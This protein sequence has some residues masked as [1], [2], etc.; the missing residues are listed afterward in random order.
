M[1]MIFRIYVYVDVLILLILLRKAK[2]FENPVG[3]IHTIFWN[4][5]IS[6]LPCALSEEHRMT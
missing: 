6:V 4:T 5:A 2:L 1:I 3:I